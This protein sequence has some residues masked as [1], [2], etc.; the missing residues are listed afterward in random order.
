MNL[1][2]QEIC[3]YFVMNKMLWMDS[4]VKA[5]AD[6]L[7]ISIRFIIWTYVIILKTDINHR[8][9]KIKWQVDLNGQT[10]LQFQNS[11]WKI[12]DWDA[13]S[14]GSMGRIVYPGGAVVSDPHEKWVEIV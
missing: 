1:H 10:S 3:V 14:A 11:E 9:F 13:R 12:E 7:V 2:G 8:P 5:I 4:L 6:F